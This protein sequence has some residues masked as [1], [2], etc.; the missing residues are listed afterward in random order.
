MER[1][2]LAWPRGPAQGGHGGWRLQERGPD[3]TLPE[4]RK[5]AQVAADP[6][7]RAL[8]AVRRREPQKAR[9][10]VSRM[11][12]HAALLVSQARCP[13]EMRVSTDVLDLAR[14]QLPWMTCTEMPFPLFF[15]SRTERGLGR[16]SK[17]LHVDR[18]GKERDRESQ[19]NESSGM[20]RPRRTT[21]AG[22]PSCRLPTR[23]SRPRPQPGCHLR[24]ISVGDPRGD[25]RGQ[26]RGWPGPHINRGPPQD[27]LPAQHC[28]ASGAE[29]LLP[30]RFLSP[31]GHLVGEG[32]GLPC[33]A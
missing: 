16:A 22:W 12:P 13:V 33:L 8:P 27:V 3:C 30:P 26:A 32:L 17:H 31:S 20:I 2:P 23:Q 7:A 18:V 11:W 10:Q 6:G 9:T 14:N 21:D 15:Y 5:H 25:P 4:G 28:G 24:E 19:R 1:P 29:T